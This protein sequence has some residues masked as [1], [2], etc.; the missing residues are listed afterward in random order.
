VPFKFFRKFAEIQ[1]SQL[2]G[3]NVNNFQSEK[4]KK[5]AESEDKNKVTEAEIKYRKRQTP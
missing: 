5:E 2:N 3:A 1:Y 4:F